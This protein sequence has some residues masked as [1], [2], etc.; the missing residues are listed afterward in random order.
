MFFCIVGLSGVGKTTIVN[1][2]HDLGYVRKLIGE[3]TRPMRKDEIDGVD[4]RFVTREHFD[5]NIN[6]YCEHIEYMGNKYGATYADFED[7]N[8]GILTFDA[9]EQLRRKNIEVFV[10][11]MHVDNAHEVLRNR[12]NERED[13]DIEQRMKQIDLFVEEM[14]TRHIDCRINCRSIATTSTVLIDVIKKV[15]DHIGA[16]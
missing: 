1:K 11:C 6:N 13:K 9:I 10:I 2:L 16:I 3:T 14:K 15:N 7:S 8:I 4:C 5:A 12:M